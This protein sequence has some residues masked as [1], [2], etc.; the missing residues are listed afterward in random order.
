M[1]NR[2]SR[3]LEDLTPDELSLVET[4]AEF[5]VAR[6]RLPS[7]SIPGDVSASESLVHWLKTRDGKKEVGEHEEPRG[8]Q[9]S[10]FEL[11]G[12]GK[13]IWQDIDVREYLDG[14]RSSWSG[15]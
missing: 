5:V 11:K 2:L 12:L 1:N 4:F 13:E 14:E 10:I 3:L 15:L 6:R 8:S 7:P 9:R